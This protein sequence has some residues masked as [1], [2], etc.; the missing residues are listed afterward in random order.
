MLADQ[1]FRQKPLVLVGVEAFTRS[2]P[3]TLMLNLEK[4]DSKEFLKLML[5]AKP[6]DVRVEEAEAR[7]ASLEFFW[8]SFEIIKSSA[9]YSIL[10]SQAEWV[11]APSLSLVYGGKNSK[12][13]P[14]DDPLDF[15]S[16][17]INPYI[18]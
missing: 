12:D 9:E 11:F 18:I 14:S 5:V 4:D 10:R 17:L 8:S 15:Y 2:V 13:L 3:A 1:T 7:F 6:G 16:K